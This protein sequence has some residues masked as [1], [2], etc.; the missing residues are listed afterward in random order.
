MR[1]SEKGKPGQ[2]CRERLSFAIKAELPRE[3]EDQKR[4]LT[5]LTCPSYSLYSY[6]QDKLKLLWLFEATDF[7]LSTET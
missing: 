5:H 7:M 6:F 4:N 1:V 3:R 2:L